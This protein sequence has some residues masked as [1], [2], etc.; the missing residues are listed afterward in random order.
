[1]MCVLYLPKKHV[2]FLPDCGLNIKYI[3]F[4]THWLP[5]V[6]CSFA[7]KKSIII[8]SK[9]ST[10]FQIWPFLNKWKV[11][12]DMRHSDKSEWHK[13]WTPKEW[14]GKNILTFMFTF[15]FV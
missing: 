9:Y 5:T 8:F 14:T 6:S 13:I 11:F 1:M 12:V 4:Q 10:Y 7:F 3:L 2:P 15:A